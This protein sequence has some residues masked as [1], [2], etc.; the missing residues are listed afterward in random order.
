MT[1]LRSPDGAAAL[2]GLRDLAIKAHQELIEG[3]SLP[4]GEA[5]LA[6][7]VGG[8]GHPAAALI[9]LDAVDELLAE[10]RGAPLGYLVL[11]KNPDSG[12]LQPQGRVHAAHE[13]ADDWKRHLET[14]G[15]PRI[16]IR[17]G[18]QFL[19]AE[20]LDPTDNPSNKEN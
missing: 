18:T 1:D 15:G 14:P 8:L 16:P 12:R 4:M 19:V 5:L 17:P 11:S 2:A 20:V 10:Q 9:L 6:H 13:L 3:M 7:M